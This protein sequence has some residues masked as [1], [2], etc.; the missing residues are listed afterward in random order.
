MNRG[1]SQATHAHLLAL[2]P[3]THPCVLDRVAAQSHL[4]RSIS[5]ARAVG[6]GEV[7]VVSTSA[8]ILSAARDLGCTAEHSED[9]TQALGSRG[10]CPALV[11]NPLC[12]A[13][14][15]EAAHAAMNHLARES[16]AVVTT[17]AP[18]FA[19]RSTDIASR[20]NGALIAL[21]PGV[22][23]IADALANP[24]LREIPTEPSM[25]LRLDRADDAIA[26]A[27]I[28]RAR[29][30]REALA[31]FSTIQLVVFDFD[32]VMSNNQVL[33]LQDATEGALCNRSDGLGIGMLKKAGIPAMV[34]S[35]EQNPVV[36]ARCKKLDLECHQGI[37]DKLPHL[38]RIL[39]QRKVSIAHVAYVG[40]DLN[41]VACMNRVGLP[42]AVAD[43]FEPALRAARFVTHANGGF[44]AVR[45]VI[46]LLILSRSH[47]PHTKGSSHA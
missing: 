6:A 17:S 42:I 32:G 2:I 9:V 37:D 21:A 36:G 16:A 26:I 29:A 39:E 45:E 33:V 14:H 35:K 47:S 8:P 1:T 7:R 4:S 12:A 19:H 20:A 15:V 25:A 43:A 3:A 27:A 24:S 31:L 40:N 41:D 5:I 11:L 18:A 38:E 44:G 34:L 22:P 46:D 30:Q 23:S 10:S 13:L 28:L